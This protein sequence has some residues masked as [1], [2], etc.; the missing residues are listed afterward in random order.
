MKKTIIIFFNA[1]LLTSGLFVNTGCHF[2]DMDVE[3]GISEEEVFS[4][5]TNALKFI[6]MVF[7]ANTG[8]NK[9]FTLTYPLYIEFCQN[10]YC[11]MV[12]TTDAADCGRLCCAQMNFKACNLNQTVLNYYTFDTAVQANKP[13]AY[14]MFRMIRV[15]NKAIDKYSDIK[16]G[17]EEEKEDYLGQAYF[18]RGMSH[19]VLCRY[20]GGMPYIDHVI[21]ADDEWDIPRESTFDTYTKAAKDFEESYKH[22]LKAEEVSQTGSRYMRRNSPEELVID[23]GSQD[24]TFAMKKP[25]GC[26]ALAA[27]ARALL[28][29]ASPLSNPENNQ[30]IWKEAADAAAFAIRTAI[31]YRY[32]L[33]PFEKITDNYFNAK[34]TNE[35]IGGYDYPD[36][37][38]TQNLAGMLSY[39][40]TKYSGTKGASGTHPTQNFVDRFETIDGYNLYDVDYEKGEQIRAKAA[41]DGH[42]NPQD[43]YA[44][45]D[46]RLDVVIIHDGSAFPVQAT[47]DGFFNIYYDPGTG[48]YPTTNI[49]GATM[50]YAG[51]W[52][53]TDLDVQ[54]IS[55]TGYYCQRHW[56]GQWSTSYNFLD[57]LYRLG[58]LYLNYAEAMNEYYGPVETNP[59][60]PELGTAVDNV[61]IV[62]AR[63]GMPNVRAEYVAGG[64]DVMRERIRNERCVE[65]AYESNHYYF[66]IRRWKIAPQTMTQPLYGMYVEKVPVSPEYPVGR[67]F[68]RTRIPDN[69]QATWKDCMYFIPF[70]DSQA[71]KM[72]NFVNNAP[73]K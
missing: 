64:K 67:K 65:L 56:S 50:S 41:A 69:R 58:E 14:A 62:R 25:S 12:A 11:Q 53:S 47:G 27:K 36:K 60:F 16:I 8:K 39:C 15:A 26:L 4:T 59:D 6:E 44:N 45:R 9:A 18:I 73:W 29:A 10:A 30:D 23:G 57:P 13:I 24:G 49:N 37:C 70:P 22:F 48:K 66:D 51:A 21:G 34:M 32:E 40:Q 54:A 52:G 72:K 17:K 46:P 55:N 33:Q 38:N 71:N 63:C 3:D 43:P 35:I 7:N 42:Y 31:Q 61:N 19:F 2:L 68:T 1:L 5:T 20:F 28:Y